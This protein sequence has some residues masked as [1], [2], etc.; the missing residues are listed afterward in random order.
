M[1]AA[2]RRIKRGDWRQPG[3]GRPKLSSYRRDAARVPLS[4]PGYQRLGTNHRPSLL[5]NTRSESAALEC[6]LACTGQAET[7]RDLGASPGGSQCNY[8]PVESR[9]SGRRIAGT[10]FRSPAEARLDAPISTFALAALWFRAC[11]ASDRLCEH[12][13][14]AARSRNSA[15]TRICSAAGARGK[16]NED[17]RAVGDGNAHTCELWRSCGTASGG[18]NYATYKRI[19]PCRHSTAI[20]DTDRLAGGS[21]Y[22]GSYHLYCA[23]CKPLARSS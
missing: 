22:R 8:K 1:A 2:V 12:S 19:W 6:G 13:G 17:C 20:G 11:D 18:R 23:V 9:V 5:G 7:R 4:L 10:R 16:A 15:R 14:S 3:H 21:I